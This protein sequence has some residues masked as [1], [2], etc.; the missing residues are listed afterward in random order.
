LLL[1]L[2][3]AYRLGRHLVRSRTSSDL[4]LLVRP[5]FAATSLGLLAGLAA[6]YAGVVAPALA[7]MGADADEL[8]ASLALTAIA[9]SLP[10]CLAVAL[11]A[12]TRLLAIDGRSGVVRYGHVAQ[13]H[14]FRV[15]EH[16]DRVGRLAVANPDRLGDRVDLWGAARLEKLT[17]TSYNG[18]DQTSGEF[19]AEALRRLVDE[20]NAYLDAF[21]AHDT[22]ERHAWR[23]AARE[24]VAAL[25]D[26][27]RAAAAKREAGKRDAET[28]GEQARAAR[29]AEKAAREADARRRRNTDKFRR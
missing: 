7:G 20:V 13:L 27:R 11:A 3:M 16:V 15:V 21:R 5:A 26:A 14:P 6:I 18:N 29:R 24:A 2:P 8:L 28:R 12:P 19:S 1:G 25:L 9:A 4:S 10:A 22:P 17:T 23:G